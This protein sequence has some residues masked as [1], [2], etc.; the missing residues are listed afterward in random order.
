M[1]LLYYC[2][3]DLVMPRWEYANRW[4]HFGVG[5]GSR[6]TPAAG[7]PPAPSARPFT[8][9]YNIVQLY[10]ATDLSEQHAAASADFRRTH[11][12]SPRCIYCVYYNL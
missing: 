2:D 12:R 8:V 9:Y 6:R 4:R 3:R 5:R 10:L 11:D 7:P 1:I